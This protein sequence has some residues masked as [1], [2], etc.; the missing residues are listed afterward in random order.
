MNKRLEKVAAWLRERQ[1][2][3]AFIHSP[4]NVYYLTGFS[5][6]PHERLFGLFVFPQAEPFLVLPLLE[7]ERAREAGWTG[8]IVACDDAENPWVRVRE[9]LHHR[10]LKQAANLAV[11]KVS[12]PVV[13]AEQLLRLLPGAELVSADEWLTGLRLIKDERELDRMREAARL[14]D[15]AVQTGI[16]SLAEGVSE[17]EVLA[18]IELEM[19]K[20]GVRDMA[21]STMVLFGENT[22]HPHSVPG[23]R[24]LKKGD[25]VLFDLGVMLDGYCSDITRTVA[26]GEPNREQRLI[27]ETVLKAQTKAVE[28]CRP[29]TRLG[30]LDRMARDIIRE[31]G[32]GKYFT[33]R[34]GHG[35]GIDV[36]EPPSIHGENDDLLKPGMVFTVEP[37]I[38]VPGVGGVRIEDDVCVTENEPEV[39][40]GFPKELLIV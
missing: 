22:A 10:G 26:F 23:T 17:L 38:Y 5:C 36:H 35:L 28:A 29:G 33:H 1:I 18:R 14:A 40:T 9:R 2:D 21:F 32:F 37:G 13:R 27:Y 3:A 6:H 31:A 34:L 25:L 7:E 30:D 20:R 8:D 24:R 12:L 15:I 39:L 11:E 16:D 4:Q 19:K